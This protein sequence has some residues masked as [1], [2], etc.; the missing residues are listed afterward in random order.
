MRRTIGSLLL[1]TASLG[2]VYCC[3]TLL[4]CTARRW[5][6][7]VLR[8]PR[9]LHATN[10]RASACRCIPLPRHRIRPAQHLP[11]SAQQRAPNEGPRVLYIGQIVYLRGMRS[12]TR[13]WY[14]TCHQS[15]EGRALAIV[16]SI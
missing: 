11:S 5:Q 16:R 4:L 8:E 9:Q 10:C 3:T 15:G 1:C 13:V 7:V 2:S 14:S 6:I 12:H